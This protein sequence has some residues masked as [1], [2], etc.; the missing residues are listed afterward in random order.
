MFAAGLVSVSFRE[1]RPESIL[2]VASA[3]GLSGIE[4][5]GDVHVPP[6]D[7]D[8]AR[9]VAR[10]TAGAGLQVFAY[11][12]YY[13]LGMSANPASDFLPVLDTAEALGAPFI[14]LWGG[15]KGSAALS[16]PEFEQMAGEMRILAGLAAE[17]EITL[18]LECHAGTLT[19]D[20][21]SSLRFLALVGRPNVQMYWQPNQFRSFGY[22]LEAARALAPH[23]AHLH[24]FHWDARGRYP[25]REGEAD[26]R[27]YLAAF[28]EAGGN[29]ALLLEFM[30]DGRLSTLRE[31]AATLKEWLS[32]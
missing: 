9:S 13:R 28:R 11:G 6:G 5:G 26:W 30:H 16:R 8:T 15:R 18:T 10:L 7:L 21:P 4:W 19:D 12:S 31:T 20:Y 24:V 14:R 22:N 3:A 29:H 17:R 23:T 27:A 1:E 25:L 2:R 32:S